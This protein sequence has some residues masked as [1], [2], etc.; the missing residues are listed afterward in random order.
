MDVVSFA[1]PHCDDS[2]TLR[3]GRWVAF[4]E[5]PLHVKESHLWAWMS[6]DATVDR[7][8]HCLVYVN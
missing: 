3:A 8:S 2:R 5:G 1:S 7:N 6:G 4:V